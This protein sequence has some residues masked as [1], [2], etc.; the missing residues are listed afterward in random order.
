VDDSSNKPLLAARWAGAIDTVGGNTLA[1]LL[2]STDRRGC[3]AAC[4]LVGGADLKLSVY[5]FILRGVALQ[6]IDSAECPPQQR[7]EIWRKLAGPWKPATLEHIPQETNLDS[8]AAKVDE[9]LAG[10]IIGRVL[11]QPTSTVAGGLDQGGN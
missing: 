3:V 11:V 1:T 2:R 9:I 7:L 4:G 5:P 10:K 6:G 8:L